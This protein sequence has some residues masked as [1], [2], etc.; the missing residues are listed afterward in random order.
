MDSS[1]S[2]AYILFYFIF[3]F[4]M[5]FIFSVTA[6]LQCSVN[7]L[8]YSKVT[9]PHIH[10]Y[11]LF[12][13]LSSTMLHHKWLDIVPSAVQQEKPFYFSGFFLFVFYLF[14]KLKCSWFQCCVNV[15]YIAK[16]P[17]RTYIYIFFSYYLLSCSITSDWIEFLVLY[18][19]GPHC[20]N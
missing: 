14:F 9:Q 11:I 4:F 16:W 1:W 20:F 12:L 2:L 5:I 7:F 8:L 19:A 10:I 17:N 3:N 15:F 13:T 18:L 6:G